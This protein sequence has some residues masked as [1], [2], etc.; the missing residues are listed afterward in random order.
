MNISEVISELRSDKTKI[1][2]IT[3]YESMALEYDRQVPFD[4]I[5]MFGG[6]I[7][8]TN[9]KSTVKLGFAIL[10]LCEFEEKGCV[11]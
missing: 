2:T 11:K 6:K 1:F 10:E 3:N 5:S 9:D 7:A 8:Y 4:E